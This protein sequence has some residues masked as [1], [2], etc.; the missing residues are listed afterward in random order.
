MDITKTEGQVIS[1]K[2]R[3]RR[4]DGY[5]KTTTGT[6]P[7]IGNTITYQAGSK[8]LGTETSRPRWKTAYHRGFQVVPGAYSYD[9]CLGTGQMSI[10]Q[11]GNVQHLCQNS[12]Y[13]WLDDMY[14][15][16]RAVPTDREAMDAFRYEASGLMKPEK[17]LPLSYVRDIMAAVKSRG[18][19]LKRLRT[20]QK[21]GNN[22]RS[23][24][25]LVK[26][27]AGTDLMWKFAVE[28][29]ASDI[30][31]LR[32]V[33]ETFVEHVKKLRA[34]NNAEDFLPFKVTTSSYYDERFVY[35]DSAMLSVAQPQFKLVASCR[36][37]VFSRC[38]ATYKTS[39]VVAV[40]T[41]L[42]SMGFYD[43]FQT[44]W[45]LTP[46]SFLIDWIVDLGDVAQ[47]L[48][49]H[50][51]HNSPLEKLTVLEDAWMTSEQ[52]IKAM[53]TGMT[54]KPGSLPGATVTNVRVSGGFNR[55]NFRRFPS[56]YPV[57]GSLLP[58][59]IGTAPIAA[60]QVATGIQL[61]AQRML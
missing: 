47:W 17:M 40:S 55:G 30:E 7:T 23:F 5:D 45:D 57:I 51:V 15:G 46:Y 61:L 8:F 36:K 60:F 18:S 49:Q 9:A 14:N 37:T 34:R 48:D 33:T 26:R 2:S 3:L 6:Q 53:L 16:L 43:V 27:L 29:L 4:E 20:L 39:D 19:I 41:L 31:K 13:R 54:V 52:R 22:P 59:S 50:I 28:P 58:P 56:P 24:R 12:T 11:S 44:A 10:S 1:W 38:K 25:D 21:V 42:Q 32:G 35:G